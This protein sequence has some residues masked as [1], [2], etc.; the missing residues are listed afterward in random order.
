MKRIRKPSLWFRLKLIVWNY[1]TKDL[2]IQTTH[3]AGVDTKNLNI[4][5]WTDT[6]GISDELMSNLIVETHLGAPLMVL[7]PTDPD[8]FNPTN[9]KMEDVDWSKT[10]TSKMLIDEMYSIVLGKLIKDPEI[11]KNMMQYQV[12]TDML[13]NPTHIVFK[14]I[15]AKIK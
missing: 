8:D 1:L 9:I 5:Q 3:T 15:A 13:G 2:G 14:L 10:K 6:E 7:R 11:L 4:I 12:K